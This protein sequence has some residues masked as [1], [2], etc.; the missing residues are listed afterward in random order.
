MMVAED[1]LKKCVR[2][3]F[4]SSPQKLVWLTETDNRV[5]GTAF[6][7][8]AFPLPIR[9]RIKRTRKMATKI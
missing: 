6:Y 1:W 8:P 2:K 5:G 9:L 4:V 7:N 3:Y